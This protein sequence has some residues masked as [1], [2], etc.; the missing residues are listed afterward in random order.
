MWCVRPM[1]PRE[2]HCAVCG[3]CVKQY[4]HHCF[5]INNCVGRH[6][7]ARFIIFLFATEILL[8]WLG[9]V[10]VELILMAVNQQTQGWFYEVTE[11]LQVEVWHLWVAGVFTSAIVLLFAFPLLCLI[12]VQCKNLLLGRTTY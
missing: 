3:I 4:D 9:E 2:H 1:L 8:L 12:L 7:L 10:A 11:L 5:W 6:N